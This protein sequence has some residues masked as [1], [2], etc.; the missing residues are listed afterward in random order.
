MVNC[1]LVKLLIVSECNLPAETD[2][3][4]CL[5]HYFPGT[6]HRF[7]ME[8]FSLSVALVILFGDTLAAVLPL[9]TPNEYKLL[10]FFII[11]P[12]V[13]LP[14][15]LLSLTSLISVLSTLVL[16]L[17]IVTDSFLKTTAPGSIRDP[18]PTSWG[19][20]D[21]E[22][23][24]LSFGLLM[25]GFAG[26]AVLP[27]LARDMAEP[28]HFD[29][30]VDTAYVS[31]SFRCGMGTYAH[32]PAS[33]FFFAVLVRQVV[34]TVIY[35]VIAAIGYLMFGSNISEEVRPCLLHS[36]PCI[37]SHRLIA[38][39]PS[40]L[41]TFPNAAVD[42]LSHFTIQITKNLIS[43]PGFPAWL[44]QLALWMIVLS[45]VSKFALSTRPVSS[46]S[47]FISFSLLCEVPRTAMLIKRL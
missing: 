15:R 18:M 34:A 40:R 12:T 17:S 47:I 31:Y 43:T 14:L 8:L 1:L 45:P 10:G 44:N 28:E 41:S 33:Y 11:L 5:P 16:I 24:P 29:R 20:E 6:R 21:W 7:C 39:D 37:F 30:M 27:S 4:S 46:R 32:V 2:E 26:H 9:L 13:F 35:S 22:K 38:L 36:S 25:S 3:F 42:T 23:V 19:V